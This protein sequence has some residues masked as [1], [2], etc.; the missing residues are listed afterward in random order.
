[1]AFRILE[2]QSTPNPNARKF[3]LDQSISEQSTSFF[4]AASA[5]DH[6][7]ASVLFAVSGVSSLLLLG[8]FIT[9]NK[10]PEAKWPVIEKSVRGILNSL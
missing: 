3:I 8:D 5:K 10:R 6:P 9:V 2:V 7:V 1:M 4:D